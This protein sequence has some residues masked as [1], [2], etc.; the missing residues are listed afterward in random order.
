[1]TR[2]SRVSRATPHQTLPAFRNLNGSIA[3]VLYKRILL[4][5]LYYI[6]FKIFIIKRLILSLKELKYP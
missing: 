4:V 2:N 1:M 3:F 6:I 5:N